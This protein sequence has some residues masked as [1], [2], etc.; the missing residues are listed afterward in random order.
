MTI[1]KQII[2]YSLSMVALSAGAGVGLSVLHD[3]S[4]TFET[5]K[6]SAPEVTTDA[7]TGFVIPDSVPAVSLVSYSAPTAPVVE[8]RID[9]APQP[10]VAP[11]IVTETP[12]EPIAE[13]P[14][15]DMEADIAAMPKAKSVTS[16]VRKSFA[17]SVQAFNTP[18]PLT[19]TR[20]NFV[21]QDS[22][23]LLS[24][25]ATPKYVVGVYR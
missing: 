3:H 15:E 18:A 10:V 25:N 12:V 8:E 5:A 7:A 1:M 17:P 9:V 22:L 21:E 20:S 19:T 11:V 24:N 2:A 6:L 14:V 13:T 4:M 16:T 23:Q